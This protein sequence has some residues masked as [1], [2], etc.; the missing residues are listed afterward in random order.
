MKRIFDF[1]CDDHDWFW[2]ELVGQILWL[3]VYFLLGWYWGF[4][5]L[6][7]LLFGIFQ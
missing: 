6:A 4:G 3:V 2:L 5:D 7:K 1:L